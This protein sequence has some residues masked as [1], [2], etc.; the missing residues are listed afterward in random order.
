MEAGTSWTLEV[1]FKIF[2]K[3]KYFLKKLIYLFLGSD[4]EGDDDDDSE[5]DEE[6]KVSEGSEG[7]SIISNLN[8]VCF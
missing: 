2:W 7:K 3:W 8:T 6:F 4:Q 1:I 5:E